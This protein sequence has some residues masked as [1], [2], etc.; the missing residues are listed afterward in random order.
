MTGEVHATVHEPHA[1]SAQS[2]PLKLGPEALPQRD[3]PSRAHHA[4]PGN[5]RL[6]LDRQHAQRPAHRTR[7]AGDAEQARDLAVGRHPSAGD[8]AH[9]RPHARE[10][11]GPRGGRAAG[12]AANARS[13][14]EAGWATE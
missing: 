3:A 12:A 6:E 10:E 9:G 1:L 2:P 14:E 4:M 8:G 11:R 5:A 7:A 13:P